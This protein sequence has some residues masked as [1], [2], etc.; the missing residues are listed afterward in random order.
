VL[1]RP[2]APPDHPDDVDVFPRLRQR[3]AEGHPVPAF[4]D[5]GARHAQTQDEAPAR[6]LVDRH[7]GGRGERRGAGRDLH[8]RGAD[9]DAAGL[10]AAIQQS[11]E[12]ASEP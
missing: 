8:D 11:G 10:R 2:L 3:L 6:E 9:L 12:T 7:R 4:H 1:D 5:L